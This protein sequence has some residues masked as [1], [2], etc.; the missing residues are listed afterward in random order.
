M[1]HKIQVFVLLMLIPV[2][3]VYLYAK[4]QNIPL[5]EVFSLGTPVVH[6]ADIPMTV[7]I[8]TTPEARAQGLSGRTDM[9]TTGMLFVFDDVS[10]QH[11]I[12]M[13]GMLFPIDI[14]WISPSLKVVG[15][16]KGVRPD[17]YPKTYY[18][19]EAV[20]YVIETKEHYA[21]TFLIK[22]G[23]EVRLPLQID[24]KQ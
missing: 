5:R 11:G 1:V 8:V 16:E 12:W 21:D 19:P 14:I 3:G 23:D 15:I 9:D 20:K 2:I 7:E 17:S 24:K 13:K 4:S 18:P 10:D 6:I 22:V